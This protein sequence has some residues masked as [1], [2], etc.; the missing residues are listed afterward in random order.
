MLKKSC[1]AYLCAIVAIKTYEPD[2]REIPVLQ[3]FLG[4][5]QE[6]LGLPLDREIEFIIEL[7]PGTALICKAPCRVAPAKLAGLK[8][9]LQELLEKGLIYSS[10][11]P[12]GNPVLF[13]KKKT[14]SLR[15][16]T[17]YQ[18][19]NRVTMKRKYP[20]PHIDDLFD[21]L[22]GTAVFS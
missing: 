6:V 3:E 16:C 21:Q 19:L 22:A 12:W 8:T 7:V 17:D 15:L 4:V 5:F 14:K 18:E 1:S 11:S 9:Q 13:I 2:P 20:L 10:M